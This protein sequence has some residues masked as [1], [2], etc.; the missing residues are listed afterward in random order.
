M[1]N[2]VKIINKNVKYIPHD[3]LGTSGETEIIYFGTE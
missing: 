3:T 2:K 1:A